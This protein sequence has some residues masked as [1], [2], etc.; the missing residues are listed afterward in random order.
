[1]LYH[2]DSAFSFFFLTALR[3]LGDLNSPDQGL[4]WATAVKA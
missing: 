4:I 1:M 3:G 2:S